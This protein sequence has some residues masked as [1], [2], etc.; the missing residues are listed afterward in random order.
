MHN[1]ISSRTLFFI[2]AN[3]NNSV[4]NSS[5]LVIGIQSKQI[6]TCETRIRAPPSRTRFH[7]NCCR[8]AQIST[9]MPLYQAECIFRTTMYLHLRDMFRKGDMEVAT[10]SMFVETMNV[11]LFGTRC[12]EAL[13]LVEQIDCPGQYSTIFEDCGD[14]ILLHSDGVNRFSGGNGHD[15]HEFGGRQ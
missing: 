9:P 2:G 8:G 14:L 4:L 5:V 6:G 13:E 1:F 10:G 11:A 12:L 7:T 15:M 3:T